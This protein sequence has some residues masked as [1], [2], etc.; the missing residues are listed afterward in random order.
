MG[1]T[2]VR[3]SMLGVVIAASLLAAVAGAQ[4]DDTRRSL[5]LAPDPLARAPRQLGMGKL[6]LVAEGPHHRIN[7]WDFAGN[8]IGIALSESS[9]TFDMRPGTSAASDEADVFEG[10]IGHERQ[11]LG[12][13]ELRFGYEGWRRQEG[14]SSAYGAIGELD[15]L[16]S[17]RPYDEDLEVRSQH[18][19]PRIMPV[20]TGRMPFL[21]PDR[22]RYALRAHYSYVTDQ[23]AYRK[24]VRNGAGEYIDLDGT[25][26]DPPDFFTPDE[27]TQTSLG[28]GGAASYALGDPLTLAVGV[29]YV[30]SDLEALNE[31]NRH[32]SEVTEDRPYTF[33]QGTAVGK[34]GS[35]EYGADGRL[36]RSASEQRWAFTISS[37]V[38]AVPLASRGKLAERREVG[39]S[40]RTRAR[41]TLGPLELGVGTTSHYRKVEILGPG[42]G[43]TTSFNFFRNRLQDRTAADSLFLPDSLRSGE[44]DQRSWQ[45][46]GGAAWRL[47]VYRTVI[48][49][50]LHVAQDHLE[51]TLTGEGPRRKSWEARAGAE[52]TPVPRL[53]LR[54]GYL[55]RFEDRDDFTEANEFLT[56][57][58]T[59]G[60]GVHPPTSNWR[61]DAGYLLEWFGADF[62]DP[63]LPRGSR[64]NLAL[65]LGWA[66]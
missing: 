16:R 47:P 45:I 56:N 3:W 26:V 2:R 35:L 38:G 42:A 9:S 15:R 8:P 41:W 24:I 1:P 57:G 6:T 34:I 19:Q 7:L 60:V 21:M 62:G 28:I 5:E 10:P 64:Q 58:V 44:T 20:I 31:G 13:R 23:D 54:G 18:A 29:D 65:Q 32:R 40:L 50:E 55:H 4:G 52:W 27:F 30:A 46:G 49:A 66:F 51:G 37:G 11:S 14:G 36:W 48:G 53:S 22:M 63:G 17:D 43:D 39:G 33:G 59:L 12:A 61:L 25:Q